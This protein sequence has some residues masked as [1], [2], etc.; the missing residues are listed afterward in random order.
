MNKLIVIL[1][2]VVLGLSGLG[3]LA[4]PAEGGIVTTG[5][6]QTLDSF[7]PDSEIVGWRVFTDPY[8]KPL[9]LA[10]SSGGI[11]LYW[12]SNQY[13]AGPPMPF[14]YWSNLS[15]ASGSYG[16]ITGQL[17]VFEGP[18]RPEAIAWG[19][20]TGRDS[21][22]FYAKT[23]LPQ[24][25]YIY[26]VAWKYDYTA[27]LIIIRANYAT[28]WGGPTFDWSVTPLPIG[29]R[30]GPV[31]DIVV[32]PQYDAYG[33]INDQNQYVIS[34][35]NIY[36]AFGE[37]EGQSIGT[38][39][40]AS[41]YRIQWEH[42]VF[43]DN[44]PYSNIYGWEYFGNV[45]TIGSVGSLA[46]DVSKYN[47]RIT[48]VA[49]HVPSGLYWQASGFLGG[50]F[51][52]QNTNVY[53]PSGNDPTQIVNTVDDD[54]TAYF[55]VVTLSGN[56][57]CANTLSGTLINSYYIVTGIS[58]GIFGLDAIHRS[59]NGAV[60]SYMTWGD[61]F[62]STVNYYYGYRQGGT[63][64]IVQAASMPV[65]QSDYIFSFS[66]ITKFAD[67]D[68]LAV[69]G[70]PSYE[71]SSVLARYTSDFSLSDRVGLWTTSGEGAEEQLDR[72]GA[73]IF[74]IDKEFMSFGLGGLIYLI[75][76]LL[77]GLLLNVYMPGYGMVAGLILMGALLT[78]GGVLPVWLLFLILVICVAYMYSLRGG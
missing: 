38:S 67:S 49:K 11:Q 37:Y 47:E 50:A 41:M 29:P 71:R 12:Q 44:P 35:V 24:Y 48:I 45:L 70:A 30:V 78:I 13:T 1:A 3:F 65:T 66:G 62:F 75:I 61:S 64:T 58:T 53:G 32:I 15:I 74:W 9:M 6:S 55:Y 17:V 39:M 77:P 19:N 26:L 60:L 4:Q 28:S 10:M 59:S 33:T 52:A 23:I 51:S 42:T 20:D 34:P 22:Y 40:T 14:I 7:L 5:Y 2:V 57:W 27:E 16:Y 43:W 8:D 31:I 73:W 21:G 72:S 25:A 68:I 54:G 56:I 36:I 18:Q 46:L 63:N 69:Y 76:L